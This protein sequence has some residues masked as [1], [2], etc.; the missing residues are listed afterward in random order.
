MITDSDKKK[1][2]PTI[3][4]SLGKGTTG[5]RVS[6][7]ILALVLFLSTEAHSTIVVENVVSGIQGF[8]RADRWVPIVLNVTSTSGDFHGTIEINQGM[9]FFR[10]SIDLAARTKKRIVLLAYVSSYY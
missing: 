1:G 10:K 7:L 9:A 6:V 4:I 8:A 5:M 2:S 3:R